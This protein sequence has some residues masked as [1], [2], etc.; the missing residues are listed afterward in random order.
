LERHLHFAPGLHRAAVQ[1]IHVVG[2]NEE[3]SRLRASGIRRVGHT[4][5]LIT[6]H[7]T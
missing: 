7:Q 6:Q 1:R 5:K 4:G 3:V 2:V